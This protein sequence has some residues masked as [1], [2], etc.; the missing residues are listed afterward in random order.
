MRLYLDTSVYNR[1][2][3]D[4][5]QP[6]IQLESLAVALVLQLIESGEAELIVSSVNELENDQNPFPVR[7]D[8]I[9]RWFKLAKSYQRADENIRRRAL[10]LEQ[11][12]VKPLD[13]LHAAS[14]EAAHAEW[15]LTCDDR[16]QKRYS[17]DAMVIANPT[18]FIVKVLGD[19][20]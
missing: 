1:P 10:E 14:A 12:G 16:L 8:W 15:F 7:Q 2:F 5:T 9:R 20:I 18:V 6:R 11:V 3:D 17:S 13:A 19:S 4:Q